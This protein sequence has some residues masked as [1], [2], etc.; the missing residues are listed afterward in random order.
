MEDNLEVL[1]CDLC[2]SSIAEPDVLEGRLVRLHGKVLGPCCVGSIIADAPGGSGV[3]PSASTIPAPEPDPNRPGPGRAE[4]GKAPAGAGAGSGSSFWPAAL[5][6]LVAIAAA[7]IF[8]DMRLG[9]EAEMAAA[10]REGLEN[11]LRLQD[12]R[13]TAMA[14]RVDLAAAGAD[15][16]SLRTAFDAQK[17]AEDK[18]GAL[19]EQ[20]LGQH[21]IAVE[22]LSRRLGELK[23]ALPNPE[24]A[25]ARLRNDLIDLR[26]AVDELLARP[27]VAPA[28]ASPVGG[29]DEIRMP[30]AGPLDVH[31]KR[32]TDPD[33]GTRFVAV[34]E[35]LRSGDT[36]VVKHLLPMV[37]DEDAFV[38]RLTVEGLKDYRSAEV[39]DALLTAMRDVE[40]IVRSTAYDSLKALTG[41]SLPFDPAGNRD[42]RN[43]AMRRW[44]KWWDD[45]RASF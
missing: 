20:R 25:I 42:S 4:P 38:R 3:G 15:V 24:E 14:E 40:E 39:V 44:A 13:I 17:V 7:T 22:G 9:D 33:P 37:E 41:E 5:V 23:G 16:R 2:N 35:L 11:G 36:T 26:R 34:D 32:L 18:R 21:M 12:Q 6:M 10:S 19:M 27:A 45:H 8:L 29:G 1:F 28:T 31:V 30:I 43:A